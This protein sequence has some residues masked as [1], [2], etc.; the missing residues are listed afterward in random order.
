MTT[1]HTGQN[2]I[3]SIVIVNYKTRNILE[4][5]LS[6]IECVYPSAQIIVVDNNSTDGSV[7]MVKEKFPKVEMVALNKNVGL[8]AGNNLG[9]ELTKGNY[10]VF[11]GSD[12]FPQPGSIDVLIQHM[13]QNPDIGICVGEVKLRNGRLDKDTHRG[14]PTPWVALMHFSGIDKIFHHSKY[15]GKYFMLYENLSLPHEIDLCTSHF[16]FTRKK[17][18]QNIGKWDEQFFVYGEDVDLCWRAKQNGWKI[19]YFPNAKVIHYKGTSVGIRKETQDITEASLETKK[20]M[21]A[22]TAQAMKKFYLKHYGDRG[23]NKIIIFLIEALEKL[24]LLKFS[25]ARYE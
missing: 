10:V 15:F 21:Y 2:E 20:R 18:F 22:E 7:E 5:C 24:R 23:L 17:M 11:M 3:V 16:M 12:T 8:A 4:K 9:L 1:K 25:L 19:Y 6:N 13:D 14:F